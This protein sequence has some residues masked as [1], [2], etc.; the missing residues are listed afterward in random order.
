[1]SLTLL[2]TFALDHYG[3]KFCK[4]VVLDYLVRTYESKTFS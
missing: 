2:G 1:M 3:P 4:F